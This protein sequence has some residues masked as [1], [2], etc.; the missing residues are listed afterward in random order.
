MLKKK[1]LLIGMTLVVAAGLFVGCGSKPEEAAT[2]NTQV[3]QKAEEVAYK[4]GVYKAEGDEFQNG[5]K[6]TVSIEVKDGKIVSADW[7]GVDE[8]GA[9]K[10]DASKDGKYPMV[11]KAGAKAPWHEQAQLAEAY[12]IE[13]QDPKNIKYTDD[14]GHTD[15]ISGASIKVSEFFTLAEKALE[16][17]K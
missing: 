9:T 1:A 6:A 15:A 7:N 13:T 16:E 3:E 2:E 4:D 10:K 12:L 11:E 5:W 17:A 8:E 14:E